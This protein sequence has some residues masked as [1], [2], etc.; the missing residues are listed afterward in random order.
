M[1]TGDD[2]EAASSS[3]SRSAR[4]FFLKNDGVVENEREVL[5]MRAVLQ[6]W[7]KAALPASGMHRDVLAVDC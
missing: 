6:W 1:S 7:P 3:A 4:P 5:G 2:L